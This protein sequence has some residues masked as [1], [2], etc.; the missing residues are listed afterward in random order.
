MGPRLQ[1]GSRWL[2]VSPCQGPWSSGSWLPVLPGT[3]YL[4]AAVSAVPAETAACSA[5]RSASATAAASWCTCCSPLRP[6]W[7]TVQRVGGFRV[8]FVYELSRGSHFPPFFPSA[9]EFSCNLKNE[10]QLKFNL[11]F[12]HPL[13]KHF[14][15]CSPIRLA[16]MQDASP[17][18]LATCGPGEVNHDGTCKS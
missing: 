17:A 11:F 15:Y 14:L 2:R 12:L 8:S 10:K 9:D 1:S 13:W 18:V 6:A 3:H 4:V 16:E 7:A 5:S